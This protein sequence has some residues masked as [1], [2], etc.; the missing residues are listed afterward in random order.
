MGMLRI[1]HWGE[2]GQTKGSNIDFEGRE[3]EVGFL[4]RRQQAPLPTS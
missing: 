4:G 2:E 3:Q 1:F